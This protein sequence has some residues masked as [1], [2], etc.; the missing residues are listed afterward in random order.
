VSASDVAVRQATHEDHEAVAAITE[1][2][3]ADRDRGDY[4]AEVFPAWVE[5]SG[6]A[7]DA[8]GDRRTFVAERDGAVVGTV[9]A[10]RLSAAEAWY[11]GMRVH[12]DHRGQGVSRALNEACFGWSRSWG[13]AVGRLMVYSWNVAGLGAAHAHGFRPTTE[14]RWMHPE[15]DSGATPGA[16]PDATASVGRDPDAAWTYWTDS[17]ARDHLRGLALSRTESWACAELTREALR[18]AAEETAVLAVTREGAPGQGG[19]AAATFRVRDYE[20]DGEHLAEYGVAAWDDLPALRD[21]AAAIGRDAAALGADRTR[22]LI[23]ETARHV[24]EA[25]AA[26]IEVSDDPDFVLAADLSGE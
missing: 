7:G 25:A 9:Q 14:F 24:T 6:G 12:P 11:Q 16:G 20:R 1:R 3:W 5:A 26:G 21:L 4:L 22:V 8:D 15:P 10:V 2:T 18:T 23:P 13:A 19:T 17:A